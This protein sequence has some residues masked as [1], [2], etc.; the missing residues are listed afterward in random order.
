MET[1]EF[2]MIR[3]IDRGKKRGIKKYCTRNGGSEEND[4]QKY[5]RRRD[6]K[7]SLAR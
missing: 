5:K 6:K 2:K 1:L 3:G 4:M 7:C